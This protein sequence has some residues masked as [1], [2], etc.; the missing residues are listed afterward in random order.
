M[1]VPKLEIDLIFRIFRL[2][3]PY[4]MTFFYISRPPVQ[5]VIWKNLQVMYSMILLIQNILPHFDIEH[6]DLSLTPLQHL[7]EGDV[8]KS[9]DPVQVHPRHVSSYLFLYDVSNDNNSNEN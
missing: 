1:V 2:L 4:D 5:C 7:R 3:C 9:I 8:G 6:L